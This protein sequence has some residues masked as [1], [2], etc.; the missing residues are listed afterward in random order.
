MEIPNTF[1]IRQPEQV[2][3]PEGGSDDVDFRR[4][5]QAV[6]RRCIPAAVV[7]ALIL[8]LSAAAIAT[9]KP[10]YSAVGKLLMKPD[11]TPSL[12]GL[13]TSE[14]RAFEPL[15]IQSNPLKT[16]IEILKSQPLLQRAIAELELTDA[17][18]KPPSPS[19]VAAQLEVDVSG[20]TDVLNVT[21]SA[22]NPALTAAMVNTLMRLY[23]ANNIELHQ[24]DTVTARNFIEKELPGAEA[25]VQKAERALS[26]FK[27]ANQV[28]TIEDEARSAV[29]FVT[30][31]DKDISTKQSE[32]ANTNSQITAIQN[33]LQVSAAQAIDLSAVSQSKGVQEALS[34][35]QT[36]ETELAEAQAFFKE[37]SPQV[38]SLQNKANSV[39]SLLQN[40]VRQVV[41]NS[42]AV[43]QNL[44][45]GELEQSLID[46]FITL[47]VERMGLDSQVT[48][49]DLS[50][51]SY[52]QRMK[53]LPG[54]ERQQKVL[55]RKLEAVQ[56]TYETL[57]TKLQELKTT[58]NQSLGNARI[59]EL[60][61]VPKAATLS[62]NT[63]AMGL[64]GTLLSLLGFAATVMLLE[65]RDRTAKTTDELQKIYS[66]DLLEI[67]PNQLLAAEMQQSGLSQELSKELSKELGNSLG[68]SLSRELNRELSRET[69]VV[70][71]ET[72]VS[73]R[74]MPRSLISE[75]YRSLQI[76]LQY[77]NEVRSFKAVTVL[78]ATAEED[79]SV[80]A[81]NLAMATAELKQKI[82]LIDGNLRD[83]R[84]AQLWHLPQRP[85]HSTAASTAN[86][87]DIGLSTVL[88][89]E[90]ALQE[91]IQP[92]NS[93]LWVLPAGPEPP[94]PLALLRSPKMQ[95]LM[96]AAAQS[97]DAII[98]DSPSLLSAPDGLVLGK[99]SDGVVVVSQL[100]KVERTNLVAASEALKKSHQTVLGLVITG[101]N[102][103]DTTG[104]RW[105]YEPSAAGHWPSR[106]SR[107]NL[108]PKAAGQKVSIIPLDDSQVNGSQPISTN[109][110]TN[111]LTNGST[112]GQVNSSSQDPFKRQK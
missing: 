53:D 14:G 87:K 17:T 91:A 39:R 33:R 92:I 28:V 7:S 37:S 40:R 15:T 31:L 25:D 75:I 19:A 21:F 81:A 106:P 35:L 44:Q 94:S 65:S 79:H 89:G 83:P 4:F 9:Q 29:D 38:L 68:S 43:G 16:E 67:V 82:L 112:N 96:R 45:I 103:K 51:S 72:L 105:L 69:G 22:D 6:K 80:V 104:D 108:D 97:F 71:P 58:E 18:G 8:G 76:K 54:L 55:E 109:G 98:I 85:A 11:E 101:A 26:D 48:A 64:G 41:G 5:G 47:E 36:V 88:Q 30:Q 27:Q 50:R 49:L 62:K 74:D 102:A 10:S 86:T 93:H 34:E 2:K 61:E 12:T 78:S 63:V 20:G 84:Q 107:F 73:V 24:A 13:D 110:S 46:N 52:S 66:C 59:I 60:A 42:G 111:G 32:L 57:L 3:G 56:A 70:S 77:F 100:G 99:L 1:I 95:A 23:I 90:T